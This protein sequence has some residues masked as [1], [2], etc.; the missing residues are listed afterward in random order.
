MIKATSIRLDENRK[1]ALEQIHDSTKIPVTE[2]IKQ[3]IDRVIETYSIYIPDAEFRGHLKAI[4]TDSDE[5]LKR[6][7]NE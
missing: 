7:A 1:K 5:Y 2:L 3:G 6:L 4:M